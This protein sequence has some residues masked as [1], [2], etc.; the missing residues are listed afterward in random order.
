MRHTPTVRTPVE[1]DVAL[2]ILAHVRLDASAV[3]HLH[4]DLRPREVC[5]Q[6]PILV[7]YRAVTLVEGSWFGGECDLDAFAVAGR[8]ECGAILAGGGGG[9]GFVG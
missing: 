2:A 8:G 5:P 4:A 6:S 3:R 1:R 9:G 7:A